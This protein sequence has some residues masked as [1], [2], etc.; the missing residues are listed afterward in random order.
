MSIVARYGPTTSTL[1]IQ[2]PGVREDLYRD[3]CVQNPEYDPEVPEGSPQYRPSF[4]E[5]YNKLESTLPTGLFRV[6]SKWAS[7]RGIPVL[8]E[9]APFDLHEGRS[10]F[11][12]V[13]PSILP[14]VTL[15]DY[16]VDA[17]NACLRYCR[18][19]V[20]AAT[21]AGKS[22]LFMAMV[23]HLGT[24]RTLMVVPDTAAMYEMYR[25]FLLRGFT[26]DEVGLIGD[27]E[28][29]YGR[30]VTVAV[31]NSLY[32]GVKKNRGPVLQV[33]EECQ[34]LVTDETHHLPASS[35]LA[36]A[37]RC[38]ADYRIGLSGTPYESDN[39]R[40]ELH[41]S[42]SWITAALGPPLVQIPPRVLQARGF[43]TKCEVI[44]FG[45]KSSP[46]RVNFWNVV[47]SRGVVNNPGRNLQVATIAANL[48]DQ[49]RVPLV[50]VERLEH[51]R[52][53][54]NLLWKFGVVSA[55]SYGDGTIFVP[56]SFAQEQSLD[57]ESI[58]VLKPRKRKGRGKG[59]PPEVVGYE[60]DF[61]QIPQEVDIRKFLLEGGIKVLVGSRIY[62]ECLDIPFLT[63]LINASGGKAHQ[64][65]RQKMGRTLRLFPG[66]SMARIWDPYDRSHFFLT[67][68]SKKRLEVARREGYPVNDDWVLPCIYSSVRLK[69]LNLPRSSSV[70]ETELEVKMEITIPINA[71]GGGKDYV[72][73]KPGV[74]LKAS[75]EA[76][77]DVIK[78]EEILANR[79]K[80]LFLREAVRQ[81][82]A[83]G[84][85][86]SVGFEKAAQEFLASFKWNT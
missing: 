14:G 70:K 21:G 19:V 1:E 61:V 64:R 10:D 84:R 62:D 74:S 16:Q 80:A 34:L 77:D 37:G 25:R 13:D 40:D 5:F 30:Q 78:C 9:G 50:S 48:S 83:A 7:A 69:D 22:E 75:L 11:T 51:G 56:L 47:Y 65:W 24:P 60:R 52:V 44:P 66:K 71:S 63:D 67:N 39:P 3:F 27:S 86:F 8:W 2:D 58:P 38:G 29:E 17:V 15:R 4:F 53:I 26:K 79:V 72:F 42:D 23:R 46:V 43:L 73:I 57:Y 6:L 33:L 59:E 82:A 49:G 54:Q 28:K 18:G 55:C 20:E 32:S 81:S 12:P 35:W 45:A 41:Y 68:H 36:V 76:G 31:I 85:I